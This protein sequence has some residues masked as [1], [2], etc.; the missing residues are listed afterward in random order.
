[1]KFGSGLKS[2]KGTIRQSAKEV[3]VFLAD[4]TREA[5]TMDEHLRQGC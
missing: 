3:R 5:F 2:E 4:F 1:M